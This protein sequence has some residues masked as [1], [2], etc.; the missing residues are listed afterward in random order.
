M[1]YVTRTSYLELIK[2]FDTLL[3]KQR[4][5]IVAARQRYKVGLEKL[6]FTSSQVNIMQEE[7]TNLKPTLVKTVEDTNKLMATAE[8]E[9][10]QVYSKLPLC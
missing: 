1:N 9:K 3:T 7:L 2:M 4:S 5:L 10:T 8:R 6:E